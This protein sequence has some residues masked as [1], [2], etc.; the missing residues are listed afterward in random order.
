MGGARGWGRPSNHSA[1]PAGPASARPLCSGRWQGR[2]EP[3]PNGP[4]SPGPRWAASREHQGERPGAAPRDPS[5]IEQEICDRESASLLAIASLNAALKPGSTSCDSARH[6]QHRGK[7]ARPGHRDPAAAGAPH[8]PGHGRRRGPGGTLAGTA[9]HVSRHWQ[10]AVPAGRDLP[11]RPSERQDSLL[12]VSA[13]LPSSAHAP[14]TPRVPV[15]GREARSE[16]FQVRLRAGGGLGKGWR[17][18]ASRGHRREETA[19]RV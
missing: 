4:T 7:P 16:L 3:S 8:R 5:F 1:A 14:R 9:V 12:R 18:A 6:T 15:R 11:V 19:G 17:R 13:T 2:R 10:E